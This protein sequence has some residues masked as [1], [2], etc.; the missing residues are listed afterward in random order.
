MYSS[1]TVH[2]KDHCCSK[3]EEILHIEIM[4]LLTG[5]LFMGYDVFPHRQK[6]S[7]D[8]GLHTEK[9]LTNID[10]NT[11]GCLYNVV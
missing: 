7:P 1:S 5:Y 4:L 10:V 11:V 9:Q 6:Y 8:I 2:H 3:L